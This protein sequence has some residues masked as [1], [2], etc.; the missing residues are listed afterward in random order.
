MAVLT[1]PQKAALLLV[2]LGKE[3]ASKVL[4]VLREGEV[5]E[6]MTEVARMHNVD[7]RHVEH[8]ID[9]FREL[10]QA[11]SYVARGGIGY[12][13]EMLE[14]TL[15]AGRAR[16]II[17]RLS[18][19]ALEL[20]FEFLRAADPRQVLTFLQDEHPQTI[21]LVLAH[22][23]PE[24]AAL[25]MSGLPEHLQG[26][27]ARRIA[28]MDRTSPEVVRQVEAV[29]EKKASS[30][31]ANAGGP[32]TAVQGGVTPLVDILNRADRATEKLILENLER[33][34]PELADEVRN[35]MFVF[36]DVIK[37][38]DRSVQLVLREV[39]SKELAVALK[40]VNE[41][42]RE[43]VLKNMS[44]RAAQALKEEI[45]LLGPVRLKNV[46]E[47]QGAVVRAIRSLEEAGQIVISRG[48]DEFID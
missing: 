5:E 48:A 37:L 33:S 19:Q 29:L 38:D 11:H 4:K 15:G 46:E 47:A 17:D 1:G 25:V 22:L 30:L 21:A 20:P 26:D 28:V 24:Q 9:E 32:E 43:K 27:I 41:T 14:E 45:D 10:A 34:D 7:S 2:H 42:V 8:V 44:E 23:H 16:E 6:I 3:R 40:G 35:R 36:E 12:A 39:D 31:L 18:A 13:A